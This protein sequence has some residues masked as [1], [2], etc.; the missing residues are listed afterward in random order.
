MA[1]VPPIGTSDPDA[2]ADQLTEL[3]L[4]DIHASGSNATARRRRRRPD[5]ASGLQRVSAV[6]PLSAGV[7]RT[8]GGRMRLASC[9]GAG[10][11]EQLGDEL[12]AAFP[13][14]G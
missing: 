4:G 1:G 8:R 11:G 5:R 13:V 2:F 9:S 12:V 7:G 6:T 3:F 14:G 10:V